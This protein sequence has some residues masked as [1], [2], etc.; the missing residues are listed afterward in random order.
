MKSP[1][2]LI[3]M[4]VQ[5]WVS[6]LILPLLDRGMKQAYGRSLRC[7]ISSLT[8]PITP[9]MPTGELR[10]RIQNRNLHRTYLEIRS[11]VF[12]SGMNSSGKNSIRRFSSQ[13]SKSLMIFVTSFHIKH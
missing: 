13:C 7:M 11:L 3:K 9:S 6:P 2:R 4:R 12:L 8:T 1:L 5:T 10:G